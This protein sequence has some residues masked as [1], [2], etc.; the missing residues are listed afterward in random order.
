MKI[1][2]FGASGG[3][4]VKIV[5]QALSAGHMVTAFIRTPAK[6]GIQHQNLIL[7]QGLVRHQ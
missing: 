4:G 5:E 6:L 7:F 2:V 1:V 3:T